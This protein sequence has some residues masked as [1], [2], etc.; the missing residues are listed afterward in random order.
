MGLVMTIQTY[1]WDGESENARGEIFAMCALSFL[2]IECGLGILVMVIQD[3]RL[4]NYGTSSTSSK[5]SRSLTAEQIEPIRLALE[6]DDWIAAVNRYREAVPEAGFT[7]PVEYVAGLREALRNQ[8]PD[9]FASPP[10]SLATVNWKAM[11]FCA[12]TDAVILGVFWLVE[13]P[14]YPVSAVSQFAYSLLFGMGAMACTSVTGI[15]KRML[16]LAP[17]LSAMILSELIVP[18]LV[19]VSSHSIGP[20]LL[21]LVFGVF[22]M[23]TGFQAPRGQRILKHGAG[24]RTQITG[25]EPGRDAGGGDL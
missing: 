5:S 6:D 10:W 24:A 3:Y 22:L 15:C 12:L 13:P 4:V 19:E 8:H 14:S 16:L 20:Y 7:E 11:G 21:G 25:P 17:A 23:H 18:R 9:K 1:V 2:S